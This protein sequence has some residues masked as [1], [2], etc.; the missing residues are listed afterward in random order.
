MPTYWM[1]FI[2]INCTKIQKINGNLK[3]SH[4]GASLYSLM[5]GRNQKEHV[6]WAD[7]AKS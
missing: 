2:K 4:G 6:L 5:G 1:I 7:H 3:V